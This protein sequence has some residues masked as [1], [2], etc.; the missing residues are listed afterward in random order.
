MHL[1]KRFYLLS[2]LVAAFSIPLITFTYTVPSSTVTFAEDYTGVEAVASQ[3]DVW[4]SYLPYILWSIYGLGVVLFGIKFV[5]NLSQLLHKIKYNP[6]QKIKNITNVLLRDA[7]TPHTFFN[8]IFLNKQKYEA[9]E[10]PEE[11]I[12]HEKTHALEKHSIDILFIEIL[13][14]VLWFNPLIYLVK[15][16][17]KLN[18]EFLADRAVIREGI[19]ASAYQQTLLAFSSNAVNGPLANSI[20]YSLIKKRFT[21]MK[22]HTSKKAVWFRSFLLLPLIAFLIFGFS[23]R[24]IEEI[25]TPYAEDN[26]LE[27]VQEKATKKMVSEYNSL[28]KK[29]N[30]MDTDNM[31][32]SY[33][34]VKRMHYIYGIMSDSQKNGAQPFPDFPEP[35][36]PPPAPDADEPK[37]AKRIAAPDAPPPPPPP[38]VPDN[39][40]KEQKVRYEAAI[41]KYKEAVKKQGKAQKKYKEALKEQEKKLQKQQKE[42]KKKEKELKKDNG[43]KNIARMEER[44]SKIT[45]R[46]ASLGK[47]REERMEG[48]MVERLEKLEKREGER[49]ERMEGRMVERLEKLEKREGERKEKMEGSVKERMEESKLRVAERTIERKERL[50]ELKTR[51]LELKRRLKDNDD[52]EN[53]PP[54]PPPPTSPLDH[55][56]SMAKKGGTFYFEGNEISSDRA[57][58]LL[59]TN[60]N[61][62]IST[63]N[64]NSEKPVVRI[65]TS[66]IVLN[67]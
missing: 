59:K 62:S 26:T 56:I 15:K 65:S 50:E 51:E 44:L 2:A 1:F 25:T 13:Q 48:R 55:I 4:L 64:R 22:T 23:S 63:Q 31:R 32:I 60:N 45:R 47:E 18:H 8:Y 42:L 46:T 36:P 14:V 10:I 58:S 43:E 40:T 17:I 28:A 41:V 24:E 49:E 33:D 20:N 5:K 29:Y 34:D 30:N 16:S 7:I 12:L 67:N 3:W 53:I 54:P 6:K 9:Q 11:V 35:P 37:M 38:P 19:L 21:V 66:P 52:G 57:I 27:F 61:I 39:A